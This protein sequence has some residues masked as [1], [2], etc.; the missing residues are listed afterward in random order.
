[1]RYR[2]L[3]CSGQSSNSVREWRV[4]QDEASSAMT[5]VVVG[6]GVFIA[7]L[8]VVGGVLYMRSNRDDL[9]DDEDDEDHDD[10]QEDSEDA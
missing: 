1:M 3:S 9:F 2:F 7:V 10:G 6:L 5:P 4:P 8:A